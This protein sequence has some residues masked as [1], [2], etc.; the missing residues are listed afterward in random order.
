MMTFS[1]NP[2]NV[3]TCRVTVV[4]TFGHYGDYNQIPSLIQSSP[5]I[6]VPPQKIISG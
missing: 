1:F 4:A 6:C 3:D 5:D 2:S